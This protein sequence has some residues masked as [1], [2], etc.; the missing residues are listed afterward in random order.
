[1]QIILNENGE[2]MA[3]IPEPEPTE[4]Y[5][6]GEGVDITDRIISVKHDET[7]TINEQGQLHVVNS[8]GGSD[9]LFA[10][11]LLL[12]CLAALRAAHYMHA[13]ASRSHCLVR[14]RLTFGLRPWLAF[15][16]SAP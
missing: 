3:N 4:L 15:P 16:H 13:F 9:S 10:I 14:V 11:L 2:L 6:A 8:G 12:L 7:I 1:M 5:N